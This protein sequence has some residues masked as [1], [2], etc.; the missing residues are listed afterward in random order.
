M[1]VIP[2]RGTPLQDLFPS[3]ALEFP[4]RREVL[5]RSS[6]LRFHMPRAPSECTRCAQSARVACSAI[7]RELGQFLL[8]KP[9]K[10]ARPGSWHPSRRSGQAQNGFFAR[11]SYHAEPYPLF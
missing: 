9:L 10:Y 5:S 11:E 2:Q 1:E 6:R 3:T 8:L 7:G 4:K